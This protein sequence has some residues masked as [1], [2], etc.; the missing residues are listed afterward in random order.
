[1]CKKKNNN[2]NTHFLSD[3]SFGSVAPLTNGR[4]STAGDYAERAPHRPPRGYVVQEDDLKDERE[5]HIHGLHERHQPRLLY[6]EG[7]GEE[8]L[9]PQAEQPDQQEE[10]PVDAA[11]GQPPLADYGEDDDALH[12]ADHD[13]V[14][15]GQKVV[16]GLPHLPEDDEGQGGAHGVPEGGERALEVVRVAPGH[17]GSVGA[18]QEGRPHDEDHPGEGERGEEDVPEAVFF[19]EEHASEQGREHWAAK[20]DHRGV[21]EGRGLESV[22]EKDHGGGAENSPEDQEDSSIFWAYKPSFSVY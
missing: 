14:P 5:D 12:E 7:L 10:E 1:M 16:H 8:H 19:L 22:V 3:A 13:V 4:T 18:E 9:T 6:L 21:G 2:N 11:V 15:D 20:G 17:P